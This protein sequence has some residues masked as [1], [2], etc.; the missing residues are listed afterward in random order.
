M[1]T[2]AADNNQTPKKK[3][4]RGRKTLLPSVKDTA[5]FLV[6]LLRSSMDH[7]PARLEQKIRPA[8]PTSPHAL[9][10][11]PLV[12]WLRHSRLASRA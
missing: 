2:I 4:G 11:S 3:T 8:P 5:D 10:A 1:S 9:A 6:V 7:W 12:S